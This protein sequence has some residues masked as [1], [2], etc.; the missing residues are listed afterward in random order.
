[1]VCNPIQRIHG[2][3]EFR[4][5]HQ[6]EP[7]GETGA[8]F[9]E[10]WNSSLVFSLILLTTKGINDKYLQGIIKN[11]LWI[12]ITRLSHVFLFHHMNYFAGKIEL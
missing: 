1:M 2:M 12:D 4:P 9:G 6:T 5:Q 7:K 8:R 3:V 11:C 10:H